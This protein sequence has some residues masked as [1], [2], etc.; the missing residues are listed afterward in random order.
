MRALASAYS[1]LGPLLRRLDPEL[2]HRLGLAALECAY[3][4]RLSP[5]TGEFPDEAISLLGLTFRNRVG[6]AAGLDKDGRHID[7]LGS[8][9]FGFLEIGTVTARPQ[10]GQPRPRLFRSGQAGALINRMGFPSEGAVAVAARLARR[11]FS[12]VCGVNIGKNADTPIERAL[13]DYV[14]CFRILAPAADY[15]AVNVSSPNTPGLRGLQ[16]TEPLANILAAILTERHALAKRGRSVPVLLKISPDLSANELASIAALTL[17][18]QLDGIIAT[19][20]T[21]TRP[22]HSNLPTEAGGLSGRPLLPASL[23][24]IEGLRAATGPAMPII[25]VG[26]IARG[27]DA[28]AMVR[29]GANLVQVYTGLV[30]QG[31]A[32]LRNVRLALNQSRYETDPAR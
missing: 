17:E 20:T 18:L 19:N 24:T 16:Q 29:A 31:P 1:L 12:G 11:T 23:R 6:L 15:I 3:R 7:A 27:E 25:G 22:E 14:A 28:V 26:G 5:R 10:S 21:L 2:A 30:Y 4:L 9:G 13:E 8:L 32:L